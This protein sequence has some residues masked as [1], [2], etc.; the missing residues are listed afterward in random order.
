MV[1]S[2]GEP[3]LSLDLLAELF[4]LANNLNYKKFVIQ[5]NGSGLT[6]LS[7]F[8]Y[9]LKDLS[10]DKNI[11]ISFSVHGHNEQIHEQMTSTP[12]SFYTLC[13]AMT[14]ISKNTNCNIYTN[15]VISAVNIKFLQDI[16]TFLKQ[17]NPQIVQFAVM[18]TKDKNTL[19][20][21]LLQSAKAILTLKGIISKNILRTEGISYCLI[22]GLEECV[23]ESY[24]PTTLDIYNK[25]D[26][27]LKDFKQLG[28][29]MRW[30]AD[31][32]KHCIMNSICAGIWNEHKEEFLNAAIK[33]IC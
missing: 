14:N 21:G 30:K 25:G 31:F 27:Y 9:F 15:T 13:K 4:L 6:E 20:V 7:P 5:T 23:G 29:G 24:W 19:S 16:T 32:C 22:K 17:F 18:H 8:L 1:F 10:K 11:S 33:P 12:G 26:Q 3:T 28:A 2:G